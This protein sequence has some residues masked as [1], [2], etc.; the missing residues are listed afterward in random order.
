MFVAASRADLTGFTFPWQ[1]GIR[2]LSAV[3]KGVG[4]QVRRTLTRKRFNH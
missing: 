4:K 1:A 3:S 2:E